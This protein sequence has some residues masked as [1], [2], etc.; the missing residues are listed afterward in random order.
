MSVRDL[1]KVLTVP[2][3]QLMEDAENV[4]VHTVEHVDMVRASIDTFGFNDPVGVTTRGDKFLIV[5]GHGRVMAARELNMTELPCILLDHLNDDERRAYALAHNQ[6]QQNTSLKVAVVAEEFD[7]LGVTA[8]DWE[9]LGY[10]DE[11]ALFLPSV[12]DGVAQVG[13]H[14]AQEA[15]EEQK[16]DSKG[17]NREGWKDYIPTVNRTTLRFSSDTGYQRFVHLLTVLREQ[18]ATAGS[19][20]ARVGI[21]LDTM[22][23]ARPIPEVTGD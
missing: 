7:R 1:G 8:D 16:Y 3:D 14:D 5:E 15:G 2:I 20:G 9:A 10:T 17:Q 19:V 21:L 18:N 23:I 4:K 22:G 13:F 11:D 12:I 6:T